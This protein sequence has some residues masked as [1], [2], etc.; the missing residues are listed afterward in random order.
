MTNDVIKTYFGLKVT[1][2]ILQLS[3]RKRQQQVA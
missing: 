2:A 1:A 3:E